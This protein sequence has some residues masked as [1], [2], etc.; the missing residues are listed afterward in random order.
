[1]FN[2]VAK[3]MISV[4]TPNATPRFAAFP[5]AEGG[6]ILS[7]FVR[8]SFCF[9]SGLLT[10]LSYFFFSCVK[11]TFILKISPEAKKTAPKRK[12]TPQ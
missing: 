6:V 12:F 2:L 8:L 4:Y 9:H 5:P 10:H 3:V 11:S 7:S 1:M